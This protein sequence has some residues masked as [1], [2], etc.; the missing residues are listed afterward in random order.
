MTAIF[1][2]IVRFLR[3]VKIE[4]KRVNWLTRREVI[5]YTLLILIVSIATGIYLGGLDLFFQWI[6]SKFVL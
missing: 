6:L 1:S 5:N 4:M 3:E 2:K